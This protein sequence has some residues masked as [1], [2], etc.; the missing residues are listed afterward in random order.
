MKSFKVD[1]SVFYIT[2]VMSEEAREI[3][4]KF[5]ANTTWMKAMEILHFTYWENV[6]EID[7]ATLTKHLKDLKVK[8]SQNTYKATCIEITQEYVDAEHATTGGTGK[9]AISESLMRKL[10]ELSAKQHRSIV[11]QA[12]TELMKEKENKA[13]EK[14][15]RVVK[16]LGE[17][18]PHNQF[19]LAV[20]EANLELAAKGKGKGKGKGKD[21]E[22]KPKGTPAQPRVDHVGFFLD[23]QHGVDVNA[24]PAALRPYLTHPHEAEN[25]TGKGSRG[26]HNA[27]DTAKG[28]GK[29][30]RA[31]KPGGST[32]WSSK[33]HGG[34]K[35]QKGKAK[36][37]GKKGSGKG[38]NKG[39]GKGG[40]R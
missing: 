15:E 13:K 19:V 40:K 31:F 39:K 23:H 5:P 25:Q 36:G 1:A 18:V 33:S 29:G 30:G 26:H 7:I 27:K 16:E 24:D 35:N 22:S 9:G 2:D 12:T 14:D 17:V 38:K 11:E 10:E 3:K 6:K 37:K 4:V 20:H 34:G 28:G 21:K 8:A 32:H